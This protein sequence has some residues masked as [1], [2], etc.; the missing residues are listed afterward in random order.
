MAVDFTVSF[1]MLLIFPQ[2]MEE[3]ISEEVRQFTTFLGQAASDRQPLDM[4]AQFNLPILNAL[5]RITVGDRFEYTDPQLLDIIHRM[6]EFFKKLGNP[7]AFLALAFPWIFQGSFLNKT[8]SAYK[9][10]IVSI[11]R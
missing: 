8:V 4:A 9:I 1:L 11:I 6:G 7:A 3:L 10:K 5:W 2:G